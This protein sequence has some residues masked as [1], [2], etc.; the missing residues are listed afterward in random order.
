MCSS[1]V[2]FDL[3]AGVFGEVHGLPAHGTGGAAK[4]GR[5]YSAHRP[6]PKAGWARAAQIA[7]TLCEA[8]ASR[9]VHRVAF[10]ATCLSSPALTPHPPVL[11][12]AGGGHCA[13]E[14]V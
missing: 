7:R 13:A 10:L 5:T 1:K 6:A 2:G 14:P 3:K 9:W 11:R 12:G 4:R 8:K